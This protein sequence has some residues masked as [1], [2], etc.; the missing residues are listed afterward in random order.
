MPLGSV[1]IRP[2]LSS[3]E[4]NVVRT[5]FEE[6]AAALEI[7]LGYQDFAGELASL[8]GCYASP[9]GRLLERAREGAKA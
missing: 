3:D 8:P 7:D 1:T 6:Y 5:L 9:R 2:A 4:I